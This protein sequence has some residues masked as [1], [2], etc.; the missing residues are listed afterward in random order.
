MRIALPVA[1]NLVAGTEDGEK[2][3]IYEVSGNEVKLVEEYDNPALK[4]DAEMSR[5]ILMIRSIMQRGAKTLITSRI[6]LPGLRLLKG[7]G[8]VYITEKISVTEAIYNFTSGNL[9]KV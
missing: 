4:T 7:C 5:E 8:K 6:G 2:I 9:K 3:R 1:D